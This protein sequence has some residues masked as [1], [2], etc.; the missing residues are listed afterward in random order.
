MVFASQRHEANIAA[1]AGTG[2]FGRQPVYLVV[3]RG[4]FV[5]YACSRP[6]SAVPPQRGDVIT[7]VLDRK[8]LQGLDGGIGGHV[9]TSKVGPGL[10]LALG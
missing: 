2:V 8:T 10:P 6:S 3:L 7:M 5:C 9:D 4:H 1:G